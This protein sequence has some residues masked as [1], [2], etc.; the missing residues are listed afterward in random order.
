MPTGLDFSFTIPNVD[1][2][3]N[4]GYDHSNA[5]SINNL[6]A[7]S[8]NFMHVNS[9]IDLANMGNGHVLKP[10]GKEGVI[11]LN[12]SDSL[13]LKGKSLEENLLPVVS[14]KLP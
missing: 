4:D 2:N 5:S 3:L 8:S 10:P 13:L 1:G 6:H 14:P 12:L 7:A 9:N 11:N